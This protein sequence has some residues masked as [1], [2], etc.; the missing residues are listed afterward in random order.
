ML[1]RI[2]LDTC[3][4]RNIIHNDRVSLDYQALRPRLWKYRISL[5]D[6]AFAE[7]IDQLT[8]SPIEFKE[9]HA[10]L[11]ELNAYLDKKWPIFAGGRKLSALAKLQTDTFC[12]I[13]ST[14]IFLQACWNL[15]RNSDSLEKLLAGIEFV[16]ISGRRKT[17][18]PDPQQIAT[19][20]EAGRQAWIRQIEEMQR[21][22]NQNQ[23]YRFDDYKAI[24]RALVGFGETD[25]PD[26]AERIDGFLRIFA[27]FIYMALK[28]R[29]PYNPSSENRRGDSFDM[30][31]LLALPLPAIIVTA[32]NSLPNRL[33]ETKAIDARQ[34][35]TVDEFN[36]HVRNDTLEE[37][38]LHHRTVDQQML[39]W[40]E[41]AYFSWAS[42]GKPGMDDWVDWLRTE[43]IA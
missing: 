28:N 2:L 20:M 41:A 7:L 30:L 11:F 5:A 42:R 23:A 26:L 38:L 36:E 12:D 32:E 21:I 16:D 22:L 1:T 17:L 19:A 31:L 9:C 6:G 14:Q 33:K 39:H 18:K 34:V 25:P 27:H 37:L 3:V 10:K 15:L 24:C 8:H 29:T 13:T 40:R 4:V 43:P 35:V